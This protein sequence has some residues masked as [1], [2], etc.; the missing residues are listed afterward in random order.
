VEI[1]REIN[2]LFRRGDWE[3]NRIV[4]D[5]E[6]VGMFFHSPQVEVVG[7][8]G[9]VQGHIDGILYDVPGFEETSFLA[10]FKTAN[11]KYFKQFQKL[12]CKKANQKYWYQAQSYMGRLKLKYCLF[13]VTNKNDEKRYIEIIEF[14][15][16]DFDYIESV[17]LQIL[18]L[19][20]PPERIGG[21]TWHECKFCNFYM[22]CHFGEKIN[23]NCRTCRVGTIE[24]NYIW[25]CDG[26]KVL[27][28]KD[29][30]IGCDKHKFLEGL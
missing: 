20:E 9:H 2:R 28:L 12:K 3:E 6:H 8:A 15:Q 18:E 4:A 23:K 1:A 11:D 30:E 21:P 14:N 19:D 22:V 7:L 29:Q 13:I 25:T 27:S 17:A 24:D 10:E 26:N 5:L 16:D